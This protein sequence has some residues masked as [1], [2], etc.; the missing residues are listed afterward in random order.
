MSFTTSL[1]SCVRPGLPP[2]RGDL[3]EGLRR[4]TRLGLAIIVALLAPV[5]AWGGII[6]NI[7]RHSVRVSPGAHCSGVGQT[8]DP[9]GMLN[10]LTLDAGTI[11]DY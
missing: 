4:R 7:R 1:R 9:M 10:Q 8:I 2:Q 11:Y 5:G 6:V 3:L